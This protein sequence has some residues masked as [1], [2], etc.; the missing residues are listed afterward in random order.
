MQE[1]LQRTKEAQAQAQTVFEKEVRRARKEA[2]K[3]SSALVKL[4]EELKTARNRYTLMRVDAEDHKQKL[5]AKEGELSTTQEQLQSLREEINASKSSETSTNIGEPREP[6]ERS[7]EPHA[8]RSQESSSSRQEVL[9]AQNELREVSE[10]LFILQQKLSK[11]ERKVEKAEMQKQVV[12]E[13][14]DALKKSMEEE[15]VARSAAEGSIALPPSRDTFGP[16]SQSEH[17]E[18]EGPQNEEISP[19][20]ARK[21]SQVHEEISNLMEELFAEKQRRLEAEELVHF[22]QMECQFGCCSCRRSEQKGRDF[23][24]DD[25][26][27]AAIAELAAA[28]RTKVGRDV[29]KAAERP[30]SQQAQNRSA[31][32]KPTMPRRP[33]SQQ[34]RAR[35]ASPQILDRPRSQLAFDPRNTPRPYQHNRS[36]TESAFRTAKELDCQAKRSISHARTSSATPGP[37]SRSRPVLEHQS[38]RVT[39]EKQIKI[40]PDVDNAKIFEIDFTSPWPLPSTTDHET[41]PALD[42]QS[43]QQVQPPSPTMDFNFTEII[44]NIPSIPRPLPTPPPPSINRGEEDFFGLGLL[45]HESTTIT[46]PLKS[47]TPE[48]FDSPVQQ[49]GISR[50]E[51]LAQIRARRGRARSYAASHGAPTTKKGITGTPRREIS[52]PSLKRM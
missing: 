26:F 8:D 27:A 20:E 50:E 44:P 41:Y 38:G 35:H 14:R 5:G 33:Q 18:L 40:E 39:K 10:E 12:E 45:K 34:A 51:A 6:K 29:V 46:I 19:D 15:Q 47:D 22:S 28:A 4:Q 21:E 49:G 36:V 3:S 43:L 25:S 16:V 2:F 9:A 37:L 42:A 13:E 48:F 1:D 24:K 52:A 23:I 31:T 17:E 11:A 32:P 7:E 30:R